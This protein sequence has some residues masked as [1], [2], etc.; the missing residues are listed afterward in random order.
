[1]NAHG[2]FGFQIIRLL[3]LAAWLVMV[4]L[5]LLSLRH[6]TLSEGIRLAWTLL[7]LVVPILGA[8]AFWLVRP[9]YTQP[10]SA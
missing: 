3:G 7:I 2:F 1:M 10:P 8:V 6:R 4:I 5:S 9:G